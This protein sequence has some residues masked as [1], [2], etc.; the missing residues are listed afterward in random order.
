MTPQLEKLE[1]ELQMTT[2]PAQRVALLNELIWALCSVDLPRATPLFQE[3]VTLLNADNGIFPPQYRADDQANQALCCYYQGRYDEALALAET[4]LS[5]PTIEKVSLTRCRAL[6]VA[7]IC[8]VRLGKPAD[9]FP[10]LLD[11]LAIAT[12]IGDPARET[13]LYNLFGILYVNL[14]D[15]AK[16]AAYFEQSLQIARKI[17]DLCSETRALGNLCMSYRDLGR[18]AESL[19]AGQASVALA[20]Q[21]KLHLAE[22]WALTSL[23]NTYSALG[24]FETAFD[25][26]KQAATLADTI[27]N[28][29]EQA[30]NLLGMARAFYK[31]QKIDLARAY[32]ELVLT[33]AQN[34]K[35]QGFQFEAHELLAA[36]EKGSGNYQ[37]ALAHYE[38]FHRIKERVFNKEADDL[39]KQLEVAYQTE[40]TQREAEIYQLRYVELQHEIAERERAQK[41][42]LQAQKLESLGILAGGVAHDFNNLLV[43]VLGQ[44][45]L[46]LHKLTPEHPARKNLVKVNEAAERAANLS[47][48]M[49]AYSGKGRF[50]VVRCRLSELL[51]ANRQLW[52][53]AIGSHCTLALDVTCG[54][55][56]IEIDKGQIE[57]LLT[58][59]IMN[60][61]EADAQMITLCTASYTIDNNPNADDAQFGQ[62]TAQSLAPG[63]YLCITI[64][65]NGSGI[66]PAMLERIFDPFFTTKFTGRGL[67]LAAGLGIVRGHQGGIRVESQL[68]VGT[69]FQ[70]LLPSLPEQ[71]K[72]P[73]LLLDDDL[74]EDA[75]AFGKLHT[76]LLIDDQVEIRETVAETLASHEIKV[77]PFADGLAGVNYYADHAH[78]IDLVLLDL[79]MVGMNGLQTW[80]QLRTINPNV[81]VVLSSGFNTTDVLERVAEPILVLQKPYHPEALLKLLRQQLN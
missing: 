74:L 17:D 18:Y 77:I 33:L 63:P 12:Q 13:T 56:L 75:P 9:A 42:L 16:G 31:G 4:V 37:Q 46:A 20:R 52:S 43:A 59:L 76:L 28:N 22:M 15:H 3:V 5:L 2:D 57:Q 24:D 66:E 72:A 64:T 10:L 67:G 69:T 34:S 54:D 38:A 58:N 29:F 60:A 8:R 25:H 47:L 65:D 21:Y 53:S 80:Q 49:L 27:G 71:A 36:I 7:A 70:V 55:P 26:F 73:S 48:K 81:K 45:E 32:A 78:E 35:Q 68:G 40:A 62:Y 41:A 61:A 6:E 50:E 19:A 23:A 79:T 30:S 44:T 51:T 1:A 11:A 39:R 14:G